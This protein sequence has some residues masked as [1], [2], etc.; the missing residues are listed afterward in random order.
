MNLHYRRLNEQISKI[1]LDIE[2]DARQQ[3]TGRNIPVDETLYAKEVEKIKNH[4]GR[5][6]KHFEE[7]L[8]VVED[9]LFVI[10]NRLYL[11][12]DEPLP[13][14]LEEVR[15]LYMERLPEDYSDEL[16]HAFDVTLQS[17]G[18]LPRVEELELG[19][20]KKL[21][22]LA[23]RRARGSVES[24]AYL[25]ETIR[26]EAMEVI[27]LLERH[28]KLVHIANQTFSSHKELYSYAKELSQEIL[29][30]GEY[31]NAK[32]YSEEL[33]QTRSELES[34]ILKAKTKKKSQL[35][36]TEN[37]P[38]LREPQFT[39]FK[40]NNHPFTSAGRELYEKLAQLEGK[41][42][43]TG[44][45]IA[46][47]QNLEENIV[48]QKRIVRAWS[49]PK[50]GHQIKSTPVVKMTEMTNNRIRTGL[51]VADFE[52]RKTTTIDSRSKVRNNIQEK[53]THTPTVKRGLPPRPVT[54]SI[55]APVVSTRLPN[56]PSL[57]SP[58]LLAN[59]R[60]L[61]SRPGNQDTHKGLP[62]APQRLPQ[63][64]TAR[65]MNEL[66]RS[67]GGLPTA[68][69]STPR[70]AL[71]T[72]PSS[73]SHTAKQTHYD[74]EEQNYTLPS[75]SQMVNPTGARSLP[76]APGRTTPVTPTSNPLPT[77]PQRTATPSQ[78]TPPPAFTPA[79][80]LPTT[81]QSNVPASSPLPAQPSRNSLPTQPSQ[82][83]EIQN[84]S[85]PL[86]GKQS[87]VRKPLPQKPQ[88][89][90][91]A[92]QRDEPS[93]LPVLPTKPRTPEN[94]A[95]PTRASGNNGTIRGMR[96]ARPRHR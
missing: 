27:I 46:S 87:R 52:L 47:L 86:Q 88:E 78:N 91:V 84:Y 26:L 71:P 7:E 1:K 48:Q 69:T 89:P 73:P 18:I 30:V 19:Q 53:P 15:R 64:P 4:Y 59:Q 70:S 66:P 36:R 25:E 2:Y 77:T 28:E 63:S 58:E 79:Q 75:V 82:E 76:T 38:P 57:P 60:T 33:I 62:Q 83:L 13:E 12:H 50:P 96:V 11:F 95:S 5:K 67:P 80:P 24:V 43:S 22:A 44:E 65:K 72:A 20:D 55:E 8:A 10:E 54:K 29:E 37:N 21:Q 17:E 14:T 31:L 74:T 49:T 40:N 61:P 41:V 81:P 39:A 90:R 3:A 93:N 42:N 34:E 45:A 85:K 56:M 68:P 51:E 92:P 23:K 94:R 35:E 16:L 32:K 6:I 9:K